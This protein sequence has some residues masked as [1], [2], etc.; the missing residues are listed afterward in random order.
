MPRHQR[1]LVAMFKRL[2]TVSLGGAESPFFRSLWRWPRICRSSVST[3]AP[4]FA[5]LARSISRSMKSRSFI[6]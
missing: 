2:A 5:A 1:G 3:S 4:H 6:T